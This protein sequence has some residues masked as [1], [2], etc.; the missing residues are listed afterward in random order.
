MEQVYG[1]RHLV[2]AEGWGIRRAAR[3]FGISRNT[4][5]RYLAGAAPGVRKRSARPRPVLERVRARMEEILADSPRWTQG[6]QRLTATRLHAML[7]EDGH[8]VGATLV[9]EYVAEWKRRRREVYVPLEY[10]PGDLGEIDFFEVWVDV[11]GKRTKAFLFLLRLMHSGRDFAWIYERQDQVSFLDGHVRALEHLGGVPH[12]LLYDNLR[13]A[14]RRVLVGSERALTARMLALATHYAFE[15]CFARPGTGHDKGGVESRGRAVRW[16]HLVPIPAGPDLETINRELLA[17][18]DRQAERERDRRGRSIAERFVAERDAMIALP[19]SRFRSAAVRVVAVSPRSL[20]QM[21]GA[22]YSVPCA[23]MGLELTAYVGPASVEIVGP[24]GRVEHPRLRFG[25]RSIRY[26]HYLP[27]LA[28]K[29]QAVRQV[30][31]RLVPELGE[32]FTTL[33][34]RLVDEHGPREAARRFTR[35]L[36]AI[37]RLGEPQVAIRVG[38]ALVHDTPLGLALADVASRAP[39][40]APDLLPPSVQGI[41]VVAPCAR[42]YDA[43]LETAP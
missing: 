25:V 42:D 9:K 38:R 40:V 34:R 29:P 35:V 4:V 31:H 33:W 10:L 36:E 39:T 43:L 21:E 26:R 1:V 18:L 7:V 19:Q 27:E 5:R 8:E 3:E 37:V 30:A 24:D 14:V 32:P 15:P 41:D 2:L 11:A 22:Y 13:P 16:Q 12:R 17:R 6:K 20:V 28:R 23:W